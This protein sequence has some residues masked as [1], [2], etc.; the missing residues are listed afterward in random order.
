MMKKGLLIFLLL[1]FLLPGCKH[2]EEQSQ[3]NDYTTRGDTVFVKN[4]EVLDNNL[5]ISEV[6]TVSYSKEISAAGTV[7]P[8]PTQFAYIAPPFSGRI[9]R[10]FVKLG[11]KVQANTPLFE[12]A[13]PDFTTAQKEYFQARSSKELAQKE[14]TRKQDLLNNGVGSQ[15]ELEEAITALQIEDKE[16]EN[17]KAALLV[18]HVNPQ[19]MTLGSPL[20]M[21]S[22]I[23]GEV[24]ADEIVT[25]QYFTSESEPIATVADLS[26]VWIVAQVKEKD[27]RFIHQGDDMEIA[28]AAF[29]GKDIRGTVY[30]IEEAVDEETRAIKVL[31][32]CD[33][34]EGFLKIGMF[35]TVH[36]MDKPSDM[37]E[38]SEKALLQGE[39]DSYVFVQIA[40]DTF[41]KTPVEVETTRD[42]KAFISKGLKVGDK[43]IS[44]GGYYLK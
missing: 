39:K 36:F 16:Y 26:K 22:P 41:I 24:I 44:E 6:S 17:A 11:Q 38:I 28:I 27:I 7:Q 15:K 30:R 21:R 25:G 32:I 2:K 34:K 5:K 43:V 9:V 37:I 19:N 31:S 29:P 20:I 40:P 23:A 12:I 10:S 14:L 4:K 8:I 3:S 33:N 42:G 13:S 1:V 35:T 18:Y